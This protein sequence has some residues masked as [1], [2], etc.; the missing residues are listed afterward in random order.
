[1]NYKIVDKLSK[2]KMMTLKN[3][4][5]SKRS[6]NRSQTKSFLKSKT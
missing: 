3:I 5:K 6:G 1:M 4:K 2:Q